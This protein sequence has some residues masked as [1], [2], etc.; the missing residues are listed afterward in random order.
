MPAFSKIK[1]NI[2]IAFR[3]IRTSLLRSILTVI[4]IALGIT[5]LTGILTAIDSIKNSLN[6]NFMMMGANTFNISNRSSDVRRGGGEVKQNPVI[7]YK[8][9]QDFKKQYSFPAVTSIY[10][11][12]SYT[13]SLRYQSEKSNPNISIIGTDDNYLTTSGYGI[14]EGR[15]FSKEELEKGRNVVLI[16]SDIQKSLFKEVSPLNKA[17]RI[18]SS[19]YT[20]IGVLESK[21][22]GFGFS[23]DR[24][25]LIPLLNA[26]HNYLSI[27]ANYR[28]NVMANNPQQIDA[29]IGEAKSCFR[30]LRQLKPKEEDNFSIT[31]SDNLIQQLLDNIKYITMAATIIG[32]ITLLG[33]S[34]GLMNIMLVTVAEKTREIGVRKAIGAKNID[35]KRQFLIEASCI[36]FLGG[37][38]GVVLGI[39]VGNSISMFIG[40][41]FI[42]PWMWIILGLL[43]SILVGLVSGIYPAIKASRLDPIES[44]RYE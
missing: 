33:A 16:G 34:I 15:N 9:A 26:K 35:I 19:Q 44:L 27:Y 20:V 18:G 21:G 25:C 3:S 43:I 38:L 32:L 5:A 30:N 23:G 6:E 24:D 7:T 42:I 29:A 14:K 12:A 8:E 36:T 1:E 4:I 22:S 40:S 41:S 2:S 37:L 11:T 31:K 13:A 17:L 10:I 39:L 28:M